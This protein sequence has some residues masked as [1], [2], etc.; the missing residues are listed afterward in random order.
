MIGG[1]KQQIPYARVSAKKA[2]QLQTATETFNKGI[3]R[4]FE[5]Y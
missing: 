4:Q 2:E 1:A 5:R 3:T